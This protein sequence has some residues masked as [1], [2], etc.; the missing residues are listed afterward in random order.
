MGGGSV[1]DTPSSI[2]QGNE[3]IVISGR[4]SD[5][6]VTL[7]YHSTGSFFWKLCQYDEDGS[8]LSWSLSASFSFVPDVS[9]SIVYQSPLMCGWTE[10]HTGT[11]HTNCDCGDIFDDATGTWT[12]NVI[13]AGAELYDSYILSIISDGTGDCPTY[14]GSI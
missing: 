9:H 3:Y 10:H 14:T 2:P 8:S 6:P 13:K 12:V 7:D 4:V 11:A 1:G 5:L